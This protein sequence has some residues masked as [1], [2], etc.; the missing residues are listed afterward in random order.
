MGWNGGVLTKH[1]KTYSA[2]WISPDNKSFVQQVTRINRDSDQTVG[3]MLPSIKSGHMIDDVRY[4]KVNGVN[5]ADIRCRPLSETSQ[6]AK[7][8]RFLVFESDSFF[9]T[10]LFSSATKQGM[11]NPEFQV[12]YRRMGVP[13]Y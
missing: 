13:N 7:F 5:V 6:S 12:M 10:I 11:N 2:I 1:G 9:D 3:S 4:Y 8:S